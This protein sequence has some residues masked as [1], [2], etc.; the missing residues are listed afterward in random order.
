M[1]IST[2]DTWALGCVGMAVSLAAIMN[3]QLLILY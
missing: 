3:N 1:T 2:S